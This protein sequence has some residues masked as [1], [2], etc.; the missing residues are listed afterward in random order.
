MGVLLLGGGLWL[1]LARER[2]EGWAEVLQIVPEDVLAFAGCGLGG[3]LILIAAWR[4]LR[5]GRADQ[6][7]AEAV[8]SPLYRAPSSQDLPV[9]D[10]QKRLA[11]KTRN[12]T[13]GH[14]APVPG[15]TDTVLG[16][17]G[18]SGSGSRRRF[19]GLRLVAVAAVLAAFGIG[20]AV[21]VSGLPEDA[22][23]NFIARIAA[24][25][26]RAVET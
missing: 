13:V 20:V 25:A 4:R 8:D 23:P 16:R 9:A 17:K 10:W 18:R 2:G 7:S 15:G 5:N 14:N 19:G 1:D 26:G 12:G 24:S 21:V 3:V 11:Q 6:G 22:V